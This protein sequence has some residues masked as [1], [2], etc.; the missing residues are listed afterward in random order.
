MR[1][2]EILAWFRYSE[3]EPLVVDPMAGHPAEPQFP[4]LLV[5]L[6]GLME[7]ASASH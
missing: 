6:C 3:I 2:D 1:A 7:S 4:T 5:Q